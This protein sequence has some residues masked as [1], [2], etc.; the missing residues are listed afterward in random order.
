MTALLYDL[1]GADDRR[2]SPFCWRTKLA[3]AHKGVDFDTVAIGFGDK[4]Q[5]EFSGQDRVPVLVEGDT[6]VP[7]SW[8]IACHLE[9]KYGDAPALF[10]DDPGRSLARF[11]N[12]WA[13]QVMLGAVARL[14]ALD[15]FQ[16]F[17]TEADQPYW[18]ESRESRLGTT[19]EDMH[20]VRDDTVKSFR[21]SLG[22]LRAS[23]SQAPFIAGET[24]AYADYI[25]F[26]NF[27][28]ARNTSP[29]ALLEKEDPIYAWRGRMLDLF[30]GLAAKAPGY[31]V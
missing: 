14:I 17:V 5:L 2:F 3:L 6:V 16:N 10:G 31:A 18:R 9:D 29:F 8:A 7:D 4:E 26:G 27:Q 24:P 1:T 12:N 15:T 23:L 20:A 11:I 22:P 19:L 13:D 28:W 21:A 25:V 30:D